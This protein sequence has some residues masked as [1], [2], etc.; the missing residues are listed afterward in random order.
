MFA[1]CFFKNPKKNFLAYSMVKNHW[2]GLLPCSREV[3]K[4]KNK[5]KNKK[6]KTNKQTKNLLL[7]LPSLSRQL[8][9]SLSSMVN[10]L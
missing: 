5:N 10:S 7:S 1:N 3:N 4:N 6:N 9:S 2:L 8:E